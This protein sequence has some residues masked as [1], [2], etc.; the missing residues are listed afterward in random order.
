MQA[1]RGYADVDPCD[2]RI[3]ADELIEYVRT[4]VRRYARE[5]QLSQTP[6]ARG[7][8]EPEMLLGVANAC[9][10]DGTNE[11]PSMLGTAVI[12]SNMDEV[13]VYLDGKLIG[14]MSKGK[15]LVDPEPAVAACTS[16]RACAK[17][18]SRIARK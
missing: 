17:A 9:L 11:A 12:E 16:S 6:T 18:T 7:D 4:N 8:Y 5:R 13:D 1:F 15:P 10:S 3:T 2:G 14:R